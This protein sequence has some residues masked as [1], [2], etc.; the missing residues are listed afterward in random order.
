MIGCRQRLIAFCAATTLL[1]ACAG[2]RSAIGAPDATPQSRA[3][4]THADRSGSWMLPEPKSEQ[5]L[6]TDSPYSE[7]IYV[8]S[9]PAGSLVGTLTGISAPGLMCSD[10]NGVVWIANDKGGNYKPG[11]IVAYVHGGTKRIA[12]LNDSEA[13]AGCS[14][15]ET[16][17]NLAVAGSSTSG[18]GI[19]VYKNAKG[20]PTYYTTRLGQPFACS[21]DSAGNLFIAGYTGPYTSGLFWLRKGS[22]AIQKFPHTPQTQPK[23]GLQ[24]DGNRLAVARTDSLIIQFTIQGGSGKESG[25]TQLDRYGFSNFWI[26]GSRLAAT[27]GDNIV[28]WPYPAGGYPSKMFAGPP[29]AKLLGGIT[30]S[31]SPKR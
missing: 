28:L 10:K 14:V 18:A 17:G 16:T 29:S 15:D 4:V 25:Q 6:Y 8:Y 21:Y 24:W 31:V 1:P 26:H 22:S 27:Q 23:W 7:D 9:Y 19:A 5:L 12:T 11:Q 3:I 2:S 13:P 30:I 20:P